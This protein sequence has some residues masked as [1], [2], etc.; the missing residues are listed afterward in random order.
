M[1]LRSVH[2]CQPFRVPRA[3]ERIVADEGGDKR[4]PHRG[5]AFNHGNPLGGFG[6][7]I[8]QHEAQHGSLMDLFTSE[9]YLV[10]CIKEGLPALHEAFDPCD[11]GANLIGNLLCGEHGM[12][13]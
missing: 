13:P 2:Q 8:F 12:S 1:D 6:K 3:R 5:E 4:K 7:V 11:V 10:Q 9:H